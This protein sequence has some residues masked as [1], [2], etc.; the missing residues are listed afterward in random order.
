MSNTKANSTRHPGTIQR[1]ID[2][3][4]AA[5][6]KGIGKRRRQISRSLSILREE[7]AA[8]KSGKAGTS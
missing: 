2:K 8:A 3:L 5:Y 7:L 1:E 4:E 6:A